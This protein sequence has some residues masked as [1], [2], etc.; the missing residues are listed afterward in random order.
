MTIKKIFPTFIPTIYSLTNKSAMK[1]YAILLFGMLIA[2]FAV[3]A[4]PKEIKET[5]HEF[6]KMISV[7]DV[8]PLEIPAV[9]E[10]PDYSWR[11]SD[12]IVKYEYQNTISAA[13]ST[14][15]LTVDVYWELIDTRYRVENDN[16]PV[17]ITYQIRHPDIQLYRKSNKSEV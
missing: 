11:G 8:N 12:L 10:A 15:I 6:I 9:M 1:K 14:K 13:I 16:K 7:S 4:V 2:S 5:K 3:L 17:S